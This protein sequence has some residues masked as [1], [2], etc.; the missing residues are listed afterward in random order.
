MTEEKTKKKP[1]KTKTKKGKEDTKTKKKYT[2]KIHTGM[3]GG[4]THFPHKQG[5]YD[6]ALTEAGRE[7]I[8]KV[9]KRLKN[10]TLERMAKKLG[11]G[12]NRNRVARLISA[13]GLTEKIRKIAERKAR[14]RL[15]GE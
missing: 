14:K 7:L 1:K 5:M 13:Y 4:I 10:P 12:M 3:K 15:R 9:A 2:P 8:L 6:T 11:P